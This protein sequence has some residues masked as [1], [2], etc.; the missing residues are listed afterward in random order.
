MKNFKIEATEAAKK[1]LQSECINFEIVGNEIV[2]KE[3]ISADDIFELGFAI[4]ELKQKMFW[5]KPETFSVY[6]D[7]KSAIDTY[8]KESYR[9][10]DSIK[11]TP[12]ENSDR[13]DVEIKPTYAIDI[14]GIGVRF[15][16]MYPKV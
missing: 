7:L 15:G 6:G 16:R 10:I 3:D 13:V 4:G 12:S 1:H 11:I 5:N 9:T 14:F 2:I 8:Q